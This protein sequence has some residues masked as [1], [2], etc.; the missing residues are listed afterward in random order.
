[1]KN[2]NKNGFT[3][4]EIII[5]IA[6]LTIIF[7]LLLPAIKRVSSNS[8]ITIGM[9]KQTAMETAA[10]KYGNANI[11][12]FQGCNGLLSWDDMNC[13][14]APKDLYE[15]GYL[16]NED[17][18][19]DPVTN[20]EYNGRIIMCYDGDSIVIEPKYLNAGES[21]ECKNGEGSGELNPVNPG[22]KEIIVT[23]NPNSGKLLGSSTKK[24]K[25]GEIYGDLGEATKEGNTFDGWY[26]GSTS[27]SKVVPSTIVTSKRNHTL[28]AHYSTNKYTI[29]FDANGGYS[30]VTSQKY[31]KNSQV[32]AL[33]IP[34]RSGYVFDGWYTESGGGTEIVTPFTINSDMKLYAHWL[35]DSS[36]GETTIKY[37]LTFKDGSTSIKTQSVPSG[38]VVSEKD[39]PTITKLHYIF[40]GWGTTSTS[41]TP[42]KSIQVNSNVVLYAIWKKK[43]ST[44]E[45][46]LEKLG[47]TPKPGTPDFNEPSPKARYK[48]V[49][50]TTE[51]KAAISVPFNRCHTVSNSYTFDPDTGRFNMVDVLR[52][53]Y[54]NASTVYPGKYTDGPG[55]AQD[56]SAAGRCGFAT[57]N[58]LYLYKITNTTCCRT[59]AST[60]T[61]NSDLYYV[62]LSPYPESFDYSKDGVYKTEDDYGNSY[63]YRGA[64][65]NNYL[66][67]AGYYWRI[68]RINGDG[69]LRVIFDGTEPHEWN[70][71]NQRDR[72][73]RTASYYKK[74][75]YFSA[76][77]DNK[78]PIDNAHVGYM[79]NFSSTGVSTS[80]AMAQTN[81]KDS[82]VKKALDNWYTS[83]IENKEDAK[84]VSDNIFCNDRSTA[85]VAHSWSSDDTALGYKYSLT[86]YG[87]YNRIY[88]SNTV[89]PSLKCSQK[90]DAFTVSDTE[91]GNG[92]LS[93]PIGLITIDEAILAGATKNEMNYGFYLNRGYT[94]WTLSPEHYKSGP[95]MFAIGSTGRLLN[96]LTGER[97]QTS[98]VVPVIN[99]SIEFVNRLTGDGTKNNPFRLEE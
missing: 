59:A 17:S 47:V 10:D 45:E 43:T 9:S 53:N 90:N 21:F 40:Q 2:K 20:E 55:G 22:E 24:L 29:T 86:R 37:K 36:G 68:V 97:V 19:I 41:T 25:T 96:R 46:T 88:S 57:P 73:I 87:A 98:A 51:K 71:T 83:N 74:T 39:F 64:G 84:Y 79:H 89:T 27:G 11:N 30:S 94:M 14:I 48:V 35:N 31:N 33:P 72:V 93:K 69:T 85:S 6:I 18:L 77:L 56:D 42:I 3:L 44:P 63:Y 66:K 80:K 15:L 54:G 8:K 61:G 23:L 65:T 76:N 28:Y 60:P 92:N 50:G 52:L 26:T 5:V 99:L 12:K 38:M 49:E 95:Y 32:N 75:T 16:E 67:F 62:T 1:M 78:Y 4:I 81:S 82:D 70:S 34:T 91:K 58:T 13:T 7:I